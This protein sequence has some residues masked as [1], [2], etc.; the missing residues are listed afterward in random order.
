MNRIVK[1]LVAVLVGIAAVSSFAAET[2]IKGTVYANWMLNKTTGAN[3]YNAFTIDRAYFGA[4][5]KLSDYTSMR[6]TFDIRPEKFSSSA[7]T[8]VDNAGDTVKIPAMTAYSGYPI[9]LK[10]AY[11]DWKIKPVAQYLKVRL[12]LQPT[13]YA[14][15]TE[16]TWGRRY[17]EKMI[18]DQQGWLS[19]SDLGIS[20]IAT[21]GPQGNLGEIGLS[22]LNGTKYSD[23]TDKNN[24][25]DINLAGKV[26]PFYNSGDFNQLT[27]FG[28]FYSGTQNRTIGLTESASDWSRQI[29]SIGGKLAYQ[30]SIDVCFDLNFQTLGQGTGNADLK[31]SGMSFWWNFYL[32][33]IAPSAKALKTLVPF[34]RIDIADPNT[35]LASDGNTLVIA[36]IECAPTKGVRASLDFR[37]KSYQAASSTDE[38]YFYL[39][40]EF[41]F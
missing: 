38:K 18:N 11:A 23:F 16:G 29:L 25:K 39:N 24:Q 3:N 19:T 31:Q 1:A 32:G 41:K 15:Y 28:Q 5:S 8:V 35:R 9:I 17:I 4:E 30:K 36:G 13:L 6:I 37:S 27:L 21:L 7:T 14:N 2:S 20:A 12:G 34:A 26:T 10:Y 22:L 33:E 40:T